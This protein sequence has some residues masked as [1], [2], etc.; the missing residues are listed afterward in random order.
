MDLTPQILDDPD[1]TLAWV[2]GS[3]RILFDEAHSTADRLH[4]GCSLAYFATLDK[5]AGMPA[6]GAVPPSLPA[7]LVDKWECA[8]DERQDIEI[9]LLAVEYLY[10]GLT[11]AAMVEADGADIL[12]R[13]L[14]S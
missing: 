3:Q 11:G 4:A 2:E 7:D 5:R 13:A 14:D 6:W 9:R 1:R 8:F 12:R 10:G